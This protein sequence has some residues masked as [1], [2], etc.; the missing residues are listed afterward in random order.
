MRILAVHTL[1]ILAFCA[2]AQRR[3]LP[4]TITLC[5]GDT[6][7]IEIRQDLGNNSRVRWLT[8]YGSAEQTKR[9]KAFVQGKY[10]IIVTDNSGKVN[11]RDST[12]VKIL[13]RPVPLLKDTA[14]CAG[15][16]ILLDAGN[17]GMRYNWKNGERTRKL[18]VFRAGTYWVKISNGRCWIT[19]TARVTVKGVADPLPDEEL[20]FCLNETKKVLAVKVPTNVPV[21]WSTGAYSNSISVSREGNYVV[22]VKYPGC[23][24]VRD[25][26]SVKL[27]ACECEV[28][29]PNSF[30]P[31]E[32]NRNDYFF[33]VLSCEYSHYLLTISDRW[34][35]VV[36]QTNNPVAKWDGR[37]KGNLCPEDIYVYTLET[38]EKLTGKKEARKGS[39]SLFR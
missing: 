10:Y 35:Y 16:E 26:V 2:S 9:V 34:G 36:F 24:E 17:P 37:F 19:D 38:T 5:A 28:L 15:T 21:Q 6:A 23:P 3:L 32:D 39:I 33:P 30:T 18:G 1:L 31:N 13:A 12:F 22:V 20:V 4:D 27:K 29:M 11:R 25:S 8:P 14:F 7:S